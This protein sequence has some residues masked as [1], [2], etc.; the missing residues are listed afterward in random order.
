MKTQSNQANILKSLH[1]KGN[2]L[3]L[4]NIWDAGSAKVVQENG[5]KAI[6][7]SSWSVAASHGYEDG[8]KIPF[9][10]VLENLKR[11]IA[12]TT[13]PVTVDIEG[14]YGKTLT[15]IQD[16]VSNVLELDV[17]GIN[18]EDQII[19]GTALY[20]IEK[21]CTRI[22]ALRELSDNIFINARTDIFFK[23]KANEHTLKE[24]ISR[25]QHYADAG[26]DGFFVP[27][28]TYPDYIKKLCES[29]PIP[30]NIMMSSDMNSLK[31]LAELGVA[32]IS[33]GPEPYCKM[34]D[35]LR[36]YKL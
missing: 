11:I 5:S 9:N 34:M 13:L 2:P 15:E 31:Q 22:K 14:A 29:S 16:N 33:Y 26:A 1:I 27:G 8:E 4:I 21:Q 19:G 7:T 20:P 12:N 36:R 24:A 35:A 18:F 23:S 17:A 10:L 3:I 32:R 25:A 6:A 28:L 30:I